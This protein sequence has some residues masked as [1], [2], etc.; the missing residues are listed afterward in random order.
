MIQH[1]ILDQIHRKWPAGLPTQVSAAAEIVA[2]ALK[3]ADGVSTPFVGGPLSIQYNTNISPITFASFDEFERL[4]VNGTIFAGQHARTSGNVGIKQGTYVAREVY[5]N[6]MQRP[7]YGR[8][9]RW[10]DIFFNSF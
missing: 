3:L 1:N 6:I 8:A 4:T 5:A 2:L 9:R 7:G 10:F